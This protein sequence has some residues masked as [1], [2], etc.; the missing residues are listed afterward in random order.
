MKPRIQLKQANGVVAIA[1]PGCEWKGSDGKVNPHFL[2]FPGF[3][4]RKNPEEFIE[5]QRA[6]LVENQKRFNELD[7]GECP[8][9]KA[10]LAYLDDLERLLT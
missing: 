8:I 1:V 2:F 5:Y 7:L 4:L 3:Y 9:T 10:S 6:T